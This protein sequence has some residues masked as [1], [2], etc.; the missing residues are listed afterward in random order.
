MRCLSHSGVPALHLVCQ[1]FLSL[2]SVFLSLYFYLLFLKLSI[3]VFPFTPLFLPSLLFSSSLLWAVLFLFSITTPLSL[4]TALSSLL[5]PSS[6]SLSPS[7]S[8]PLLSLLFL[9]P[10]LSDVDGS[11]CSI[12]SAVMSQ[13]LLPPAPCSRMLCYVYTLSQLGLVWEPGLIRGI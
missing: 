2:Y 3:Y 1:S 4:F 6:F 11:S 8:L 12:W 13:L 7:L 10:L 5:L 9:F